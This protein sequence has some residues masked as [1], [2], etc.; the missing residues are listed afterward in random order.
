MVSRR[1]IMLSV[2]VSVSVVL[3]MLFFYNP[4]NRSSINSPSSTSFSEVDFSSLHASS[5]NEGETV[6]IEQSYEGT[7]RGIP[8]PSFRRYSLTEGLNLTYQRLGVIL[9]PTT[10]PEG[11]AYSD[12][13]IGPTVDLCFSYNRTDDPTYADIVIEIGSVSVVPSVDYLKTHILQ[14]SQLV[15]AGDQWVTLRDDYVHNSDGQ[16][17]AFGHFFHN[18][19]QYLVNAKYPLTNQDLI[20]IIGSMKTPS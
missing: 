2:L 12:V 8:V 10:L 15:Q 20:T 11:T 9:V 3:A 13:Y 7:I 16:S 6:N 4:F 5:Q 19:L 1:Q 18:N 17:W 14:G